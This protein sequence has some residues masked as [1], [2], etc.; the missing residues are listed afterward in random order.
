[1]SR[2]RLQLTHAADADLESIWRF[3][4]ERS[5][6][7]SADRLEKA[8]HQTFKRLAKSPAMGSLREDLAAASIRLFPHRPYLIAYRERGDGIEVLRVLHAARDV[9]SLTV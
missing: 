1:M 6:P 2:V 5:G 3:V 9:E 8:L 7:A 4:A